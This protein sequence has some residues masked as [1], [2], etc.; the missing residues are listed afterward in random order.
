MLNSGCFLLIEAFIQTSVAYSLEGALFS[1]DL[2]GDECRVW[3]RSTRVLHFV[4][5]VVDSPPKL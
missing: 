4:Q 2:H 3:M 1:R 5:C